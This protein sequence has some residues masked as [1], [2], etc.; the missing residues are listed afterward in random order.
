MRELTEAE[1][2][3]IKE[4]KEN[5]VLEPLRGFQLDY[6]NG[7]VMVA[8]AD[9][10][11]MYDLFT[12]H[13]SLCPCN[14]NRHRIHLL[15]RDGGALVLP[16]VHFANQAS[17]ILLN[18]IAAASLM[19]DIKTVALYTHIPCGIADKFGIKTKENVVLLTLAKQRVEWMNVLNLQVACFFHVDYGQGKKRSYYV[20]PEKFDE[21]AKSK[22]IIKAR[23]N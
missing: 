10:D 9:G 22:W 20:S 1:L 2:Q 4:L 3:I 16:S 21:W 14:P 15:T 8:C 7:V 19:K 11:Q 23:K 6:S 13:A 18:E 17:N 5:D 12:T